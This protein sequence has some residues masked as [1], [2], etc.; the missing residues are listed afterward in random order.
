MLSP[1]ELP[2]SN[3]FMPSYCISMMRTAQRVG[4]HVCSAP[5]KPYG[6]THRRYATDDG[7]YLSS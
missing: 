3:S 7:E 5:C 6:R 1:N 2:T 4:K